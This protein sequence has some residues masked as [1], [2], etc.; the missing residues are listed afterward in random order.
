M[1]FKLGLLAIP[2][3]VFGCASPKFNYVPSSQSFTIPEIGKVIKIG[4]GENLI[5]QGVSSTVDV[6]KLSYQQS[7]AAYEITPGEFNK[8]GEDGKFEYYMPT[9]VEASQGKIMRGLM[10]SYP[11]YSASIRI[12]RATKQACIIS[13]VDVTV[14]GDVKFERGSAYKQT[15]ASFQQT[16][17]YNGKVGD[18]VNFSYREFSGDLARPAFNADVKYDLSKSNVVGYKGAMIEILKADNLEI[19]YKVLKGFSK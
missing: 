1:N 19:E 5:S 10:T 4:I 17:I 3:F 18:E 14:C 7:I 9:P 6:I 16:L 8:V 11:D 15:S 12:D 2:F 13:P